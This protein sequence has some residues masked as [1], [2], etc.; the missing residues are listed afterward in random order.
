M[1]IPNPG[2]CSDRALRG[3]PCVRWWNLLVFPMSSGPYKL[4]VDLILAV[5]S[6]AGLFYFVTSDSNQQRVDLILTAGFGAGLYFFYKGW[7]IFREY[8]VLIDTPEAPISGVAMGL[9]AIR[10]QAKIDQ[11]VLSPVTRTPC[12]FYVVDIYDYTRN[13]GG[14]YFMHCATD[15]DGP[16]FYLQDASGKVLVDAHLAEFD[17]PESGKVIAEPYNLTKPSLRSSAK[18]AKSSPEYNLWEYAIDADIRNRHNSK[19]Q[20]GSH[21]TSGL[22]GRYL[23][24][25]AKAPTAPIEG[26]YAD[27]PVRRDKHDLRGCYQLIESLVV[28]DHWYDLTGTCVENPQPMDANDRN[29]IKK[30]T[31]EPTFLITWRSEKEIRHTLRHRAVKYIFGGAILAVACLGIFLALHDWLF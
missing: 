7:R 1:A 22:R 23:L 26:D 8:H 24:K 12:C 18:G 30:G 14:G 11:P 16:N 13:K 20:R 10:G 19:R 28:P 4:M 3:T 9:V 5:G 29:M 21:R 6:V 31:E 27:D 15:A 2:Q 17:L 25:A